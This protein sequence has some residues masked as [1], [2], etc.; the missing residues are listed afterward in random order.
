MVV[1]VGVVVGMVATHKRT[2]Y[3]RLAERIMRMRLPIRQAIPTETNVVYTSLIKIC[4]RP[5]WDISKG[6]TYKLVSISFGLGCSLY[7]DPKLY[8]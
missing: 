1:L 6:Y 4:R 5:V 2:K 3:R 7:T 8:I